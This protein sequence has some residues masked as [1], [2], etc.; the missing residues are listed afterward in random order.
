MTVVI[1][2]LVAAMMVVATTMGPSVLGRRVLEGWEDVIAWTALKADIRSNT[3]PL[4]FL[5]GLTLLRLR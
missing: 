2:D 5:R 3:P 1:P 4:S